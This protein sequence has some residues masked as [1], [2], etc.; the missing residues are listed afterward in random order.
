[1]A[2]LDLGVADFVFF[3]M[4]YGVWPAWVFHE[5]GELPCRAGSSVTN[6]RLKR[7]DWFATAA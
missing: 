4:E 7:F 2:R 1:M 5:A 3:F 6:S